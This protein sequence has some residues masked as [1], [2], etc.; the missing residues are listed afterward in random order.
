MNCGLN[1]TT[2]WAIDSNNTTLQEVWADSWKEGGVTVQ[3][4]VSGSVLSV[5]CAS[6]AEPTNSHDLLKFQTGNNDDC[7]A[8]ELCPS[9]SDCGDYLYV[10]SRDLEVHVKLEAEGLVVDI[11]DENDESLDTASILYGDILEAA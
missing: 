4:A 6:R 11:Y 8:A 1:L 5:T 2:N 9:V 10:K 3:V 7:S